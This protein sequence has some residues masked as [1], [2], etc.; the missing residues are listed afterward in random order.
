[1]RSPRSNQNKLLKEIGLYQYRYA[2]PED[3]YTSYKVRR[4]GFHGT[5]HKYV[6]N[7]ASKILGKSLENLDLITAHL[8]HGCSIAAIKNGKSLDTSMGFSPLE[9]LMMGSRSGD[10][11]PNVINYMLKVSK[12]QKQILFFSFAPK[13]ERKYFLISVLASKTGPIKTM[14]ALYHLDPEGRNQKIISFVCG[15]K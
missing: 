15:G 1:V 11:D 5:S 8:G 6:A 4:Y 7:E 9:G 14:K 2:V 13:T 10:I 3:W 12:F